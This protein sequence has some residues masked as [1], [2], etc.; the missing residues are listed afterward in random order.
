VISLQKSKHF[1]EVSGFA[2]SPGFR[3]LDFLFFIRAIRKIRIQKVFFLFGS[4]SS[5]LCC[6][7]KK[8]ANR[9]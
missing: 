6:E 2:E 9:P 4:G 7:N 3:P 1:A 5:G 8:I